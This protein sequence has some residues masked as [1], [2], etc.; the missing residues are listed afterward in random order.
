MV[1]KMKIY[2][3]KLEFLEEVYFSSKEIN[4]F[5][6]TNPVIGNYALAYAL[7]WCKAKYNQTD[8]SY[9]SDF[10]D[11]N[12]KGLYITPALIKKCKYNIFTFNALSDGYYNKMD[13]AQFNFPQKG[14]IKALASG[15]IGEGFIFSKDE[16]KKVSYIRLGKFMGKVKVS[17]K[18]CNFEVVEEEKECFGYVNAVDLNDEFKANSFEL[19]NMHPVPLLK[20][21]KGIG[22]LYKI[23]DDGNVTYYPAKIKFGGFNEKN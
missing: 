16:L 14:E 10:E 13:R 2:K 21:L 4:T 15:N 9:K 5:F 17:Y 11:I 12:S 23:M 22:K 8:I 20:K 18:E 3:Y 19:I 7:S 1:N 6:T